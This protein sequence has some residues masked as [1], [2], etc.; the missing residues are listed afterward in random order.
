VN[1]G[2]EIDNIKTLKKGMKITLTIGEKEVQKVMKDIYNFMDKPI[3]VN[4]LIDADKAKERLNQITPEQR[5]KIYAIIRD[6]GSYTGETEENIKEKLKISFLK[7]SEEEDFSLSD[8]SKE[9]AGQFIEYLIRLC[10]KMGVPLKDNPAEGLD[11][12]DNYLKICLEEKK[13]CICGKPGEIHHEDAIG[14]GRDRT[15]YDDSQ[16]KKICLCREHHTEAHKLGIDSLK[17][18]YHVYG[19]LFN[20]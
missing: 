9:L 4:F 1:I 7:T 5:K 16:H 20:K 14:I 15:N 6:V 13:C 2:C 10:F 3:M 19:I 12:I 17:G 11:N 8:C 18:K